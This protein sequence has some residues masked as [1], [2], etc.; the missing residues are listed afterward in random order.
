[1]QVTDKPFLPFRYDFFTIWGNGLGHADDILEILRS[2]PT[3]EIISIE[4]RHI[5]NMKEFVFQLYGCDTVPIEHLRSKLKYLH[6][7]PPEVI[8]VFVRNLAPQE[9]PTG[10]HP[11][12]K[13]QCA[14]INRIKWHIRE[15]F[16]PRVAGRRSEDHVIHASDYEEQV[17]YCLRLI[18]KAEGIGYLH[19]NRYG[20]PFKLPHHIPTPRSFTFRSIEAHRLRARVLSRSKN[21]SVQSVL[22]PIQDSPHYKGLSY[23]RSHYCGYL[24]KFAG[25]FL[26]DDHHWEK[27]FRM[28]QLPED[29]LLRFDP[30]AVV[31]AGDGIYNICDGVHRAAVLVF[32]GLGARIKCVELVYVK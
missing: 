15:L 5:G 20:L 11:F 25:R 3:L 6:N 22:L 29:V 4:K 9:E 28:S 18:G 24:D 32:R 31:K 16:N 17:D 13:V 12:R 19:R 21:G 26:L 1:M 23:G 7:V 27:F 14:N 8:F 2:E 10:L 30:I